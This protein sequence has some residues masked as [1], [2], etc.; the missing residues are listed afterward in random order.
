MK[1]CLVKIEKGDTVSY[2]GEKV[3]VLDVVLTPNGIND[4]KLVA[5]VY[6]RKE[7]GNTISATSNHFEPCEDVEYEEFY[8]T[9]H[10]FKLEK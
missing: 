4:M 1:S 2:E 6:A 7:N 9:P 10:L 5:I 3:K 8:P